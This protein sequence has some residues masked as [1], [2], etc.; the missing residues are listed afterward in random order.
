MFAVAAERSLGSA[1]AS[2]IVTAKAP[3]QPVSSQTDG[4]MSLLATV[5]ALGTL[6]DW[7]VP[8]VLLL[9]QI[10]GSHEVPVNF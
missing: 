8:P 4:P 10:S 2:A 9:Q 3:A 5:R 7:Q 6:L 1:C